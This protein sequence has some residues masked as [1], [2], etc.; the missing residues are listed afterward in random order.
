MTQHLKNIIDGMRQ[1]LVICPVNEYVRPTRR[2]FLTD[3]ANLRSDVSRVANGLRETLKQYDG[4]A[5][6]K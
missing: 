4:E 2:E 1:V 5:Y 6:Y 3:N